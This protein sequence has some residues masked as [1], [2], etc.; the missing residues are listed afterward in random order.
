MMA[1]S[2]L[3][4]ARR[5]Y[6]IRAAVRVAEGC[7]MKID[8]VLEH[9]QALEIEIR[10]YPA[11][12]NL[13]TLASELEMV[14][15]YCTSSKY[16]EAAHAKGNVV[17]AFVKKEDAAFVNTKLSLIYSNDPKIDFYR[18]HEYLLGNTDFYGGDRKTQISA[19]AEIHPTASVAES[20]VEISDRV[21]VGPNAVILE[22]T[23]VGPGTYVGPGTVIGIDGTQTVELGSQKHFRISHAGGVR[24]GENTFIGANSVLVKGLFRDYTTIGRNVTIGNLVNIGHNCIIDDDAMILPSTIVSGS[25]TIGRGARVS[26]GAAIADSKRIGE[27]AWITIGAVVTT[28]V[29]RQGRVSGNFAIPH[30]RLLQ[31]I[32]KL[33]KSKEE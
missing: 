17:A 6:S 22:N 15:T 32:K 27:D 33:S 1:G 16:L 5:R 25:V 11:F 8:R 19:K 10:G 29:E 14:L 13:G 3:L 18:F 7:F 28:D 30:E 12:M 24:I 9:D 21:I 26:P 4:L 20:N 2:L 23:T 31:H